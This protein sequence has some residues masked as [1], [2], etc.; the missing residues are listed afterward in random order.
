MW[1][2]EL[3]KWIKEWWFL[4]A[5][6]GGGV[7]SFNNGIQSINSNIRDVINQ[8]KTFNEKI[9]MSER[10]REK[11]HQELVAHD[12]RL[13]EHKEVLVAHGEQIKSIFKERK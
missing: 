2:I 1:V 4:I 12:L 10:D 13:D 11:I 8:L 6:I 7:I 3:F 5:V 9:S